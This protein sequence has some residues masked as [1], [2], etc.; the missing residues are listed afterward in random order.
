MNYFS[1][2]FQTN[3]HLL[4]MK[5]NSLKDFFFYEKEA[6]RTQETQKE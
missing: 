2:N 5:N 6:A 4:C 3:R 1:H